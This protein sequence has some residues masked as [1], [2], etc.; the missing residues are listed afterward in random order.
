MKTSAKTFKDLMAWQKSI[1]SIIHSII[2]YCLLIS[3]AS[4]SLLTAHGNQHSALSLRG[5][6]VAT[7]G[8][9]AGKLVFYD[10]AQNAVPLRA[11]GINYYDA[12]MRYIDN[13]N[14]LSFIDGF[15]FLQKHSIPVVRVLAGGFWPKQWELYFNDRNEF[16][17]RL[18]RFINE[19]EKHHIGLI[20]SL[21][22]Y[23]KVTGEVVQLAVDGGVLVPGKDFIPNQPLITDK[24]GNPTYAEYT[25]DFG[26]QDSG[27]NAWI[28]H[29]TRELV[30]RYVN[31]PAI[32]G[33]EFGNELNLMVDHPNVA[34]MRNRS[35]SINHQG[36]LL[37]AT[38]S[39][40]SALPFWTGAD[41]LKRSHVEV[42]KRIFAETVRSIDP[43]R[44]I[45]SGDAQPRAQAFHNMTMH[46]WQPD[47][48]AQ[49]QRVMPIDNPQPMD[50]VTVH[51]YPGTPE[52]KPTIY[53]QN[54]NPVVIK[55]RTGQ[56]RELL[57]YYKNAADALG[58]P[59]ILGEY[60]VPGDGTKPDEKE[61]FHRFIQAIIDAEVQLSL[62]WT[63]DTRNRGLSEWFIHSGNHPNWPATPTLYQIFNEDPNLWDLSSANAIH[64]KFPK[65][66]KPD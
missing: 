66:Q 52:S 3:A 49:N 27:T 24:N 59:L 29:F 7:E 50:T 51:L 54:D 43:W 9:H 64:G 25:T 58:Q 2:Y 42:A 6:H 10:E 21:F 20:L 46:N 17:R 63:F 38:T 53:F 8:A 65:V 45:K 28:R 14:D 36:M 33:W 35:G 5:V 37:P 62:L 1:F 61:T 15:G 26:R 11:F 22:W 39:D 30:E 19:A 41:D 60:G 4:I 40:L 47:T 32:W 44:F 12:F 48:R 56:Y 34:A 23:G 31:S 18:D 55:W 13:P 16:Y 57:E